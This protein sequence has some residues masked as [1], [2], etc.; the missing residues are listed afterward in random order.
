MKA[1]EKD[2]NRRYESATSF[3]DDVENYLSD[4]VVEARPPSTVYQ[5]RKVW[6]RNRALFSTLSVIFLALV[7]GL[8]FAFSA[9]QEKNRILTDLQDEKERAEETERE[10]SEAVSSFGE[11][12][13][14][15]GLQAALSGNREETKNWLL[16]ADKARI[17]QERIEIIELCLELYSRGDFP[18]ALTRLQEVINRNDSIAA[19]ALAANAALWAGSDL[20][21]H[22][23]QVIE[24]D[25]RLHRNQ[26]WEDMELETRVF[27]GH[28]LG[29]VQ[30]RVG[31]EILQPAVEKTNSPVTRMLLAQV[32]LELFFDSNDPALA[33]EA[34]R[35]AR[36]AYHFMPESSMARA[37]YIVAL[38]AAW[39]ASV[40]GQR[41]WYL[42]EAKRLYDGIDP[43]EDGPIHLFASHFFTE[44]NDEHIS[45]DQKWTMVETAKIDAGIPGY[46]F[47]RAP[48]RFD[49]LIEILELRLQQDET[50]WAGVE[51]ALLVLRALDKDRHHEN[52]EHIKNLDRNANRLWGLDPRFFALAAAL[53]MDGK[54]GETT[55]KLLPQ[56]RSNRVPSL[57]EPIHLVDYLEDRIDEQQFLAKNDTGKGRRTMSE[58]YVALTYLGKR[59]RETA[60]GHLDRA[61]ENHAIG[62]HYWLIR[63]IHQALVSDDPLVAWIGG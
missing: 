6:K 25:E 47:W 20:D 29:I 51:N 16:I 1:L 61:I 49:D 5:I 18:S 62:V 26:N 34:L 46:L 59:K 22:Y 31:L 11:A 21:L 32:K 42:T 60:I 17:S 36:A 57:R 54:E 9:I 55:K 8:G 19:H 7:V 33:G 45:L 58:F 4:Q 40:D 63:G 24:L 38:H 44:A 43:E 13:M 12:A 50:G 56:L 15:L 30:P 28:A 39:I 37:I 10:L 14:Q 52:Q 53:I 35:N 27:L 3:S 23:R 48:S 41:E 2:R